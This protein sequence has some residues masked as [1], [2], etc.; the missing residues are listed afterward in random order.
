MIFPFDSVK[1]DTAPHILFACRIALWIDK[2]VN[3]LAFLY[4][5]EVLPVSE[6]YPATANPFEAKPTNLLYYL[7]PFFVEQGL[8]R[9]SLSEN[10]GQEIFVSH[11][12][13]IGHYITI[14]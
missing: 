3:T 10:L 8:C 14:N 4:T 12:S 6:I 1:L 13:Y 7:P 5:D 2:L 9:V 11:V